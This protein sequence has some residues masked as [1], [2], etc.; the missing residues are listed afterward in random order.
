ME[1]LS[2]SNALLTGASKGLGVHIARVLAKEGVNLVLTARSVKDLENVR[3]E[4]LTY[5]VKVEVIPADLT[6]S[7]QI[8]PLI[9][10]A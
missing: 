2:E 6:E 4:I 8:Q 3:N 5:N 9:K 10:E 7:E 1:S